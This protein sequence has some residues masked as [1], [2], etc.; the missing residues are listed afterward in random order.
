M[1]NAIEKILN[2]KEGRGYVS[3][4]VVKD[5][6][7]TKAREYLESLGYNVIENKDTG[8]HGYALT[9]CGIKLSTNTMVRRIK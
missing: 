7:G 9:D 8:G 6:D 5:M 3:G 1:P 4:I 2:S